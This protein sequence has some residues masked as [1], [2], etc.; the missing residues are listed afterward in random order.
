MVWLVATIVSF[1]DMRFAFTWPLLVGTM[2]WGWVF[3][4]RPSE[5]SPLRSLVFGL[6]ALPAILIFV[7]VIGLSYLGSA[8]SKL[9]ILTFMLGLVL[10]TTPLHL[11]AGVSDVE[12]AGV[13][14][15]A[16]ATESG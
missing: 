15:A 12:G 11:A 3:L 5:N 10:S 16:K 2:A 6:A 13:A 7:P 8:L 14:T 1:P 9:G 4:A